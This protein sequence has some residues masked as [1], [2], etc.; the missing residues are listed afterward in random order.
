MDKVIILGAGLAGL[1]AA[2][3]L[4]SD[5]E[6]YERESEVGGLCRSRYVDGFIFDHAVHIFYSRD[7]YVNDLVIRLLKNKG[8][9]SLPVTSGKDARPTG[10]Y[11]LLHNKKLIPHIRSSWIYSK[12][13]YTPYP[14]QANTFGLP[15]DVVKECVLGFIEAVYSDENLRRAANFEEWIYSTFG[16][17]IAKHFMIPFNRKLWGENLD[18]ISTKWVQERIPQPKV[19]D[20]LDG[21][22]RRKPREYGANAHFWYPSSGGIGSLARAFLPYIRNIKLNQEV[23]SIHPQENY[24]VLSS[25]ESVKYDKIISSLPLPKLIQMMGQFLDHIKKASQQLKY[26]IVYTVNIGVNR[27]DISHKHWVYFPEDDFLFYRL[28]FPANLS[29]DMCPEGTSSVTAEISVPP[30]E[31][32]PGDELIRKVLED[33]ILSDILKDDDEIL[34]A[35]AAKL[36]PAYIIYDHLHHVNVKLIHDFLYENAIYPCGRFGMWEYYNMDDAILSG[37]LAA[38]MCKSAI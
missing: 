20:V 2:Y 24:I 36:D 19:E 34:V 32:V 23:V 31:E 10:K 27:K 26:R 4:D 1:S 6:I 12:G 15:V 3:H 33:L 17:G 21:A 37:K 22:L 25:G 18:Q 35:D 8:H 14:F 29:A 16:E 30:G 11:N 28:S 9:A 38:E 7:K 13:V 5:Y